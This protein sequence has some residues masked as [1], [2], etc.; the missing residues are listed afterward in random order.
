[1]SG[2]KS[3]QDFVALVS[4][5]EPHAGERFADYMHRA[6]KEGLSTTGDMSY[7]VGNY[8]MPILG[9]EVVELAD[10]IRQNK[11]IFFETA[12]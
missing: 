8:G 11:V 12:D 2:F 9:H 5:L 1:M 6:I 7:M 10:Q 4:I 3:V